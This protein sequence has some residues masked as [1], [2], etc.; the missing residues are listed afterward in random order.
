MS[1][2]RPGIHGDMVKVLILPYQKWI[3]SSSVDMIYSEEEDI[4][5]FLEVNESTGS[6]GSTGVLRMITGKVIE[7]VKPGNREFVC[8]VFSKIEG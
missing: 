1:S 7:V 4:T 5:D 3:S 6:T 8:S 2:M